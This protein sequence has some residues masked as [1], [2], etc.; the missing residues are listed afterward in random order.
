MFGAVTSV[1][2]CSACHGTGKII[3]EPCTTCRGTGRVKKTKKYEVKIPQGI[4]NGQTIRLGGKGELGENGGGYGDLLVSVYVQP[5]RVF[6]RK[7]NDIYC[8]CPSH[9]YRQH[10]A[11]KSP[12][13]PL[14]GNRNIPS[15]LVH[16][17]IQWLPSAA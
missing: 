14:M 17:L 5:N 15:N 9:S 16:S 4:D 2:T 3:K 11:E 6:V 8:V 13:R 10:W 1:R 12:S 7:G